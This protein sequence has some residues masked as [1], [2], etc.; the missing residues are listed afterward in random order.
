MVKRIDVDTLLAENQ[1]ELTLGGHDYTLKD[2]PLDVFLS[3]TKEVDKED[4]DR[5]VLHRQLS[6]ILG[7]SK[8]E[9]K[10]VGLKAATLAINAI[11][12]WILEESSEGTSKGKGGTGKASRP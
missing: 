8:S 4:V 9:L 5:D 2:I 1:L 11:R 12:D 6:E 10:D 7:V 3:A